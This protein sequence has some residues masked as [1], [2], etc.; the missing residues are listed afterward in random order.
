MTELNTT[1]GLLRKVKRISVF[2]DVLEMYKKKSIMGEYPIRVAFEGEM[3]IDQG[4]VTRDMFSAFWDECYSSMFDGSTLLV[5]MLCP[6]TDTSVFPVVGSII[7]HAYLVS[8]FLPVR[9][10]LPCIIGILL[11]PSASITQ[12]VLCEAF[13]EYISATERTIFKDALDTS[14]CTF[15]LEVQEK[16]LS[17]LSR[18]GCRQLPTPSNLKTCLVQVAQFEF[19]CKPAAAISYMHSGIPPSHA[20]FW[21]SQSVTG[22]CS[23]YKTLAVSCRKV[24]D[25]IKWPEDMNAAEDRVSSY[26]V[27]MIGNM[28]SSLVQRFLRFVTGSSVLTVKNL[29][30]QFN[31]LS[32]VARR[33]IAHTCSCLLELP[34]CYA[35]YCDFHDEWMSIL[36][37][38]ELCWFMD[39]I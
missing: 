34:V 7:S 21:V 9:I 1:Y 3:A 36:N 19:C 2:E 15:S 16:L 22:I 23:I 29:E 20:A 13:L 39:S 28:T 8:G 14:T 11:G 32:G 31:R 5:P 24:L 12:S 37:D 4:G 25:V 27:E 30:V 6:Q 10:A 18:F 17:T 38:P 35:N 33:P 26:L